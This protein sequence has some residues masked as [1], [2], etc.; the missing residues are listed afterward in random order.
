MPRHAEHVM[1]TVFSFDLRDP[2]VDDGAL[3]DVIAWLHWVDATFSTYRDDSDINR[4]GGGKLRL[5]ECAPAVAAVLDLCAEA[6]R[7]TDGYFTATPHGRLDPSGLVKGWAVEGA[8]SR[9]AAAGSR[10]HTVSGG[11]DVCAVG[12]QEDGT[13]WQIGVVDPRDVTALATVVS[14]TDGGVA[15]SGTAERGTHICNPMTGRP[16]TELASVTVVGPRL[17]WADVYATAAVARG[18][19]ARRW[20][21]TVAGYEAFAVASDGSAWWTRG[22]PTFGL[23]PHSR[24]SGTPQPTVSNLTES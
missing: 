21:E 3:A 19:D 9:L 14:T 20:L 11:G 16:A 10:A 12:T 15:T 7:R 13:P 24:F 17:M 18:H 1:G 22:F 4:L 23:V 2:N 6:T 8:S 5:H